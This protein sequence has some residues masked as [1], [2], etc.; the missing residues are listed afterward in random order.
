LVAVNLNDVR[1]DIARNLNL[2]ASK[3]PMTIQLPVTAAAN[4]CGVD[5]NALAMQGRQQG[6]AT[7][8]CMANN[9]TLASQYVQDGK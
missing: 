4:V 9:S 7:R 3:V 1:S 5:V 8:S 2:D 6:S